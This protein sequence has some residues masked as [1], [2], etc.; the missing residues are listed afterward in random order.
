MIVNMEES[1]DPLQV[2][3]F[4]RFDATV[5]AITL[6]EDRSILIVSSEQLN[7]YNQFSYRM[8]KHLT[9]PAQQSKVHYDKGILV[10]RD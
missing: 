6:L 2:K 8:I 5:I 9:F 4:W 1:N 7:I 10:L 3:S